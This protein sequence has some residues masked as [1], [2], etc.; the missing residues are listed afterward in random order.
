MTQRN[1][2]TPD[3]A[4]PTSRYTPQRRA[5]TKPGRHNPEVTIKLLMPTS[6]VGVVA[7]QVNIELV[8]D[9]AIEATSPPHIHHNHRCR[10]VWHETCLVTDRGAATARGSA[11]SSS[12]AR[13]ESESV[14][15]EPQRATSALPGAAGNHSVQLQRLRC[16]QL[17]RSGCRQIAAEHCEDMVRVEREDIDRRALQS[18][19]FGMNPYVLGEL[20][21]R[22][23]GRDERALRLVEGEVSVADEHRGVTDRDARHPQVLYAA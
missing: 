20:N 19:D 11:A 22:F 4:D 23:V 1:T 12:R 13:R 9:L 17:D 8:G 6:A 14:A 16:R 2:N 18:A 21:D 15:A 10:L 7:D 5:G 3:Y